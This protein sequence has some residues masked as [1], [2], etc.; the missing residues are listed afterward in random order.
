MV[1]RALCDLG[2]TGG[3]L[4]SEYGCLPFIRKYR[5][6]DSCI[7]WLASKPRMEISAGST[8]RFPRYGLKPKG[9]ELAQSSK[10]N[11]HYPFGNSVLEFRT[12][13][14]EISFSLEVFRLRRPK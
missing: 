5:L 7:K 2:E 10:W 11:T 3:V 1:D 6:I 8:A 13:F 9:L 12:T 4:S 14:Q